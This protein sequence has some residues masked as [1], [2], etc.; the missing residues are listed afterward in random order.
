MLRLFAVLLVGLAL[1]TPMR[2]R[3]AAPGMERPG[4]MERNGQRGKRARGP[5]GPLGSGR[6]PLGR[7][8][9]NPFPML[10]GGSPVS[11]LISWRM[12]YRNRPDSE[13]SHMG[14]AKAL[15][16][17]GN[18]EESLE[19][20][21][22]LSDSL[23]FD[24]KAAEAAGQ[25]A[26]RLGYYSDAVYFDQLGLERNPENVRLLGMLAVHYDFLDQPAEVAKVLHTLDGLAQGGDPALYARMSMAVRHGDLELVDQNRQNWQDQG[27]PLA[28]LRRF[29]AQIWM[30]VGDP[31]MAVKKVVPRDTLSFG[32]YIYA[33]AYRRQ[34][35]ASTAV[36]MI[37]G[38]KVRVGQGWGC[39]AVLARALV[40]QGQAP[41]AAAIL[42]SYPPEAPVE[43]LASRWYLAQSQGDT[44]AADHWAK[45]WTKVNPNPL[46]RL[47]Q[48][49][50]IRGQ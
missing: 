42:N 20:F 2:P 27:W 49:I 28:E 12:E 5:D 8:I 44:A 38:D 29:D 23:L 4:R 35:E 47:D 16:R 26:A 24:A 13:E 19:H 45:A 22:Q 11:E 17:Y 18:C 36:T 41:D 34:G 30:D 31:H 50:P 1:A 10:R 21:W 48:L 14:L 32:R 7:Q 33:E 15:A 37:E 25:C 9:K 46:R 6:G 40:D 3:D 43:I 39:D